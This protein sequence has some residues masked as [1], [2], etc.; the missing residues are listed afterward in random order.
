MHDRNPNKPNFAFSLSQQTAQC[1][2]TGGG[3]SVSF[4][5][6]GSEEVTREGVQA[7]WGESVSKGYRWLGGNTTEGTWPLTQFLVQY[8]RDWGETGKY[9]SVYKE[10]TRPLHPGQEF[11]AGHFSRVLVRTGFSFWTPP[12][13]RQLNL[14]GPQECHKKV[15]ASWGKDGGN[16]VLGKRQI[17]SLLQGAMGSAVTG[18]RAQ[19]R[20]RQWTG[21]SAARKGR[22]KMDLLVGLSPDNH[23][24]GSASDV[25]PS[26]S[27]RKPHS[28]GI[29][30]T[31]ILRNLCSGSNIPSN[32][33]PLRDVWRTGQKV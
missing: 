6:H 22:K 30:G 28:W 27:H 1:V 31:S 21:S 8:I 19:S 14:R 20:W 26:S 23:T 16:M 13:P 33:C 25:G 29:E 5:E 10:K 12:V 32:A 15:N 9:T 4:R 11:T 18:C 7:S 2:L 3:V 24:I 17:P